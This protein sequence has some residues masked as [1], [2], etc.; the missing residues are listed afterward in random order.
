MTLEN[1]IPRLKIDRQARSSRWMDVCVFS[2]F[3][4]FQKFAGEGVESPTP[5]SSPPGD[6]AKPPTSKKPDLPERTVSTLSKSAGNVSGGEVSVNVASSSPPPPIGFS[7]AV[8]SPS[9]HGG[10]KD[11]RPVPAERRHVR[12]GSGPGKNALHKNIKKDSS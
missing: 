10:E 7:I 1:K 3:E 12:Q 9:E 6:R 2:G 11:N 8:G 5:K 4:V